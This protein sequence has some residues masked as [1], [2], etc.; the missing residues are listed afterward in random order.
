M[1]SISSKKI[2]KKLLI[3]IIL[4]FLVVVVYFIYQAFFAQTEVKLNLKSN[5]Y[6]SKT[7]LGQ[8]VDLINKENLTF[9]TNINNDLLLNAKDFSININPSSGVGRKNPFL[10]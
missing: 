7:K 2:N 6:V 5:A 8:Y 1:S 10:P 3:P 4:V 9:T